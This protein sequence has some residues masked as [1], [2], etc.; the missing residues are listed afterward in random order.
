MGILSWIIFGLVAGVLAKWIMPGKDGGGFI[1]TV[2]L[3]IVGAV[4]GGYIS[5]FFGF[6]RVDGFNLGSFCVAVVG[7]L[8][9]LLVYRKI[10][11]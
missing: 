1:I 5:T 11:A 6:G 4:V 8:V 7:A 3:G 10:R 9:V 2:L